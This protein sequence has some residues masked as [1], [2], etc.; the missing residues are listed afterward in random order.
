MFIHKGFPSVFRLYVVMRFM[1]PSHSRSCCAVTFS[2]GLE[3]GALYFFLVSIV[4]I[5]ESFTF[6]LFKGC[7]KLSSDIPISMCIR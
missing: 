1:M 4:L 3:I 2:T 5:C 7:E 6:S